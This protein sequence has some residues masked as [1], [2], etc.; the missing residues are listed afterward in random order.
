MKIKKFV[1]IKLTIAI[2]NTN[3]CND[4]N[5]LVYSMKLYQFTYNYNIQF[6]SN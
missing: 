2:N 5:L 1:V 4:Y 3:K 6:K